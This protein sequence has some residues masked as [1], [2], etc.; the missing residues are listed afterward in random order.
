MAP[1]LK[2]LMSSGSNKRTQLNYP[3]LSK[4]PG[5]QISSRF[6]NGAPM[7]RDTHLGEFL[8]LS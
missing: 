6:P 5:K 8:H 3:F 2:V 7:E 4:S 1:R